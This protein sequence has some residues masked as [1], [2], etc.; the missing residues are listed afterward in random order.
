[1]D[2]D[3][4]NKYRYFL[5]TYLRKKV[6]LSVSDENTGVPL[7]PVEKP[8]SPDDIKIDLVKPEDFSNIK[9]I[10]LKDAISNRHTKRK[11]KDEPLTL[12]E[13]SFLLWATQGVRR[14]AN[15]RVFR[16]VPSAGCRHP[17]ETYVA[18]F[19]VEGLDEGIYRYLP[20]SNQLTLI[21][22]PEDFKSKMNTAANGQVF[23]SNGAV[24]FIWTAIPYRTEWRYS[25]G[26]HKPIVLDAG[27]VCQN[28]YLACEAIDAGTCAIG[29]YDQDLANELLGVDGEEEF[30][31]YMSPVGKNL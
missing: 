29:S 23:A 14:I 24:N 16:N 17:F 15:G 25:Y 2:R 9:D 1:M 19:N 8:C 10:S 28:L 7:P 26:S 6:D 31:I 11:Y 4:L 18:V 3:L 30:V 12:E 21:S 13:L 27:H 20:L 5:K 22:K